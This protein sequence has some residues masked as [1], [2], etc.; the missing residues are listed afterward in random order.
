M[1]FG[2]P[3][4]GTE[5]KAAPV[6]VLGAIAA[7]R[8]GAEH[9]GRMLDPPKV[10]A[11]ENSEVEPVVLFVAVAVMNWRAGPKGSRVRWKLPSFRVD[12]EPSRVT[13]SPCPD[14]SQESPLKIS[15]V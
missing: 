1:A 13:P 14:G 4:G 15:I 6:T 9:V 11:V 8:S 3:K 7:A 2:V 5:T 10:D 12:T